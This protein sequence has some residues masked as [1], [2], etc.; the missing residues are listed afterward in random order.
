AAPTVGPDPA[1]VP[2]D[3]LEADLLICV[4]LRQGRGV[5]REA[6]AHAASDVP[7]KEP[8]EAAPGF[9][10]RLAEAAS[11]CPRQ[12]I[13]RPQ[14]KVGRKAGSSVKSLQRAVAVG[15]QRGNDV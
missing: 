5:A 2:L 9:I 14:R 3:Q 1:V 6:L 11:Q 15:L 4:V 13:A 7:L 8:H 10:R 12:A